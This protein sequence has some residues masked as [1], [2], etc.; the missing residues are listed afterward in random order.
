MPQHQQAKA[1]HAYTVDMFT[2]IPVNTVVQFSMIN[3]IVTVYTSS[4]PAPLEM[5]V[6]AFDQHFNYYKQTSL[7]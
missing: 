5:S 6:N 1:K 7:F 4:T 2:T 3:D